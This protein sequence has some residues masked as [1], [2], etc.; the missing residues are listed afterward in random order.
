MRAAA[1]I[2]ARNEEVHIERVIEDTI[3]E[4]L[5]VVLIDND[6]TDDTV[7]L[8][9]RFLRHGLLRIERLPWRGIFA[10]AEVLEAKRRVIDTLD[11]DWVM[12]LDADEWASAPGE[13]VTLLDG[14]A[15]ADAAGATC[16][17][18]NELVFIPRPREDAYR[19]DYKEHLTRYY[20]LEPR[21]PRLLRAW[22][23]GAGLDNRRYGGHDLTGGARIYERWFPLRHYVALSAGHARR[24]YLPRIYSRAELDRGWHKGRGMS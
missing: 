1:V 11:H 5:D 20:F 2:C 10:W 24:K 13:G 6:S 18:F 7:P 22:R 17:N 12:H 3:A 23:N 19:P 21:R 8:A 16:V 14:L 15:E 4:G 9:R